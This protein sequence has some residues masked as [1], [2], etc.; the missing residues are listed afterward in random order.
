MI[1]YPQSDPDFDNLKSA[2]ICNCPET[3]YSQGFSAHRQIH[4]QSGRQSR[5]LAQTFVLK[6]FP[7]RPRFWRNSP[8]YMW[9]KPQAFRPHVD[10]FSPTP[11]FQPR[12]GGYRP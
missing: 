4:A 10:G 2:A 7:H 6:D 3:L 12:T 8:H 1:L 9:V 11:F 5:N